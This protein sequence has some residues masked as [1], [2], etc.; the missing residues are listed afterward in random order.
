MISRQNNL[1]LHLGCH[2]CW[3][4]LHW[5][6]CGVDRR[7]VYGHVKFS[8]MGNYCACFMHESSAISQLLVKFSKFNQKHIII[9]QSN[10]VQCI[11]CFWLH[12]YTI[13]CQV[14]LSLQFIVWHFHNNITTRKSHLRVCKLCTMTWILLSSWTKL[15]HC[16]AWK[17]ISTKL[18]NEQQIFLKETGGTW[19]NCTL[20]VS[21]NVIFE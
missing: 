18:S 1:E 6:A 11:I 7:S 9:T 4:I 10:F 16:Y 20:L 3:V 14:T 2:T 19:Q 5:Y 12:F 15:C 21:L 8:R 17:L 13:W